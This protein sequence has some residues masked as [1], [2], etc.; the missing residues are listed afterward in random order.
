MRKYY[1][2]SLQK[3]KELPKILT[4]QEW[5]RLAY[6]EGYLSSESLNYISGMTFYELCVEIRRAS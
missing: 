2:K 4:V 3:I 5:N 6:I 1:E